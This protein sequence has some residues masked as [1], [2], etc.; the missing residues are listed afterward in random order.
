MDQISLLMCVWFNYLL[1]Q[2]I[3]AK[4]ILDAAKTYTMICEV[5][6]NMID[7][8]KASGIALYKKELKGCSDEDKLYCTCFECLWRSYDK[9]SSCHTM[10]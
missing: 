1:M 9:K 10:F 4:N 8:E 3:I 6:R 7:S 5:V 2:F